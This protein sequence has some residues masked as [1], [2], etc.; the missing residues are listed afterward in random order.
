MKKLYF[1]IIAFLVVSIPVAFADEDEYEYDDDK[2]EEREGFG[3]MERE[4][5]DDEDLAIGS[6]TGHLILYVTLGAIAASIGYTAF[7]I[8]KTKRP[9]VSKK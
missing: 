2:F 8:L 5:D 4:H 9:M 1:L 7:K 3:L 6:D